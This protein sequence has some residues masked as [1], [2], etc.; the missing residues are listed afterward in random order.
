[1]ADIELRRLE[2]VYA[3]ES[4]P[5]NLLALNTHRVRS[6]MHPIRV[7]PNYLRQWALD[8][9]TILQ[10]NDEYIPL[11]DWTTANGAYEDGFNGHLLFYKNRKTP[12]I[13]VKIEMYAARGDPDGADSLVI[14]FEPL[15]STL[16]HLPGWQLRAVLINELVIISIPRPAPSDWNLRRP[17]EENQRISNTFLSTQEVLAYLVTIYRQEVTA[18]WNQLLQN[19]SVDKNWFINILEVADTLRKKKW[20]LKHATPLMTNVIKSPWFQEKLFAYADEAEAD[21]R[22]EGLIF[23]SEQ[24]WPHTVHFDGEQYILTLET[25]YND[26][27][28]PEDFDKEEPEGSRY[29]DVNQFMEKISKELS[30]FS[31]TEWDVSWDYEEDYDE[32]SED[33]AISVKAETPLNCE[34]LLHLLK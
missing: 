15:H 31:A 23:D 7:D 20:F 19:T 30:T 22:R 9:Y 13:M 27:V 1:M 17:Y 16:S 28:D 25:G 4:S 11:D 2:R 34:F 21:L 32:G 5:E 29:G 14:E 8:L 26:T 18:S 3:K 24:R 12:I 6:G 10:S 33:I